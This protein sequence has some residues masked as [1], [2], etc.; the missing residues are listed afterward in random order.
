MPISLSFLQIPSIIRPACS[1][2]VSTPLHSNRARSPVSWPRTDQTISTSLLQ[3]RCGVASARI[4]LAA[5]V[6]GQESGMPSQ[7]QPFRRPTA[8]WQFC[9]RAGIKKRVANT[10][11]K[12]C[13][14]PLLRW[15]RPKILVVA[16]KRC[17]Q[18]ISSS[19]AWQ[20]SWL[21]SRHLASSWHDY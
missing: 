3:E 11:V 14:K 4:A 5:G 1:S 16:A 9:K 17:P 13:A 20:I 7:L 2:R 19:A 6:R 8:R 15:K 21:M 12:R 18:I 10:V